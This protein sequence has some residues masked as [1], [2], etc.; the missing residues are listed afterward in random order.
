MS[1]INIYISELDARFVQSQEVTDKHTVLL[2]NL[3]PWA[4][5]EFRVRAI[6]Q[7]G[8]GDPSLPT[9]QYSLYVRNVTMWIL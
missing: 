6:N 1:I 3:K 7:F 8:I 9:S 5:H 2:T 4:G